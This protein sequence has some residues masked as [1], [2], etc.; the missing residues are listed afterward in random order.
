M[1]LLEIDI[2]YK[3][4]VRTFL[5]TFA[6]YA[7]WL[8]LIGI[9]FLCLAYAIYWGPMV[10]WTQGFLGG[11]PDLYIT[12]DMLATWV[13]LLGF[14]FLLV[15]YL[16][17]NVMFRQY[18]FTLDEHAFRLQTGL[19]RIREY[20]FPYTQI[21]NVHIEQPY[22]WRM[23]GLAS[24]D[25]ISSSDNVNHSEKRK[26]GTFLI[27]VI[28]KKLAKQLRLQLLR[29]G[30]GEGSPYDDMYGSED[31]LDELEDMDITEGDYE[32]EDTPPRAVAH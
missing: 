19:F 21:A 26:A 11:Y 27:P 28:D 7:W 22:H 15:A 14:S 16:R 5:H 2:T 20:T 29:Y 30:S 8:T 10:A 23:L 32:D 1:D 18:K 4:G 13:A 3:R 6:V 31:E 24:V 17:A 25:I 9:G 12:N